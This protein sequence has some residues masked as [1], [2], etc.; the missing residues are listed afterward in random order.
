[1][2]SKFT[3]EQLDAFKAYLA[4]ECS[5][6][7]NEDRQYVVESSSYDDKFTAETLKKIFD[8]YV[9][10][11]DTEP[12]MSFKNYL[13]DYFYENHDSLFFGDFEWWMDEIIK[14]M[15]DDM[16]EIYDELS[17]NM[18]A[19]EIFEEYGGYQGLDYDVASFIPELKLNIL[20]GTYEDYNHENTLIKYEFPGDLSS[21]LR[22]GTDC[23]DNFMTYLIHQQGYK[24]EDMLNALYVPSGFNEPASNFLRSCVNELNNT[25]YDMVAVTALIKTKDLDVLEA[26]ARGLASKER[27]HAD[28]DGEHEC[29]DR[30][31]LS[32]MTEI[33]LFDSW[34]GSGSILGI[35]LEKN[36]VVPVEYVRKVQFEGCDRNLNRGW[37]VN[38]V[39]GLVGS[40]WRD[41]C[42]V[43]NSN[44]PLTE[45]K[46]VPEKIVARLEQLQKEVEQDVDI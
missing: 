25:T 33:G 10:S 16:R 32:P 37:S 12:D 22:W 8:K 24:V 6:Y 18:S 36:L 1:M 39:Y 20:F 41:T 30:L 7:I 38:D 4:K 17:S 35:E 21:M 11:L 42:T 9:E 13:G 27:V 34:N 19:P 2:A 44:R 5:R 15:S 43:V 29:F 40:S 14:D 26:L 28:I 46:E 45:I 23:Y 3:T 31:E